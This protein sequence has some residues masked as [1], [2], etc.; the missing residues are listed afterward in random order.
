MAFA[1]TLTPTSA[2][3]TSWFSNRIELLATTLLF[4]LLGWFQLHQTE[5]FLQK[6]QGDE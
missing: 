3:S 2:L 5:T 1:T 4:L 6:T